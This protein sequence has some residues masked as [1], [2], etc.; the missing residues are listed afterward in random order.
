MMKLLNA[1]LSDEDGSTAIEYALVASLMAVVT[2]GALRALS[3]NMSN[4]YS[5]IS[6]AV[7]AAS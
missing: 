2:I 4:K 1:F 5:L 6:D 7:D 3:T